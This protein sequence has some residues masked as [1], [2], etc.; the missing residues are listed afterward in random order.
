M[1]LLDAIRR[2][3]GLGFGFKDCKRDLTKAKKVI[4]NQLL[5]GVIHRTAGDVDA[6]RA[7]AQMTIPRP[8]A[9]FQR[10]LNQLPA[11]FAFVHLHLPV[12]LMPSSC[13]PFSRLAVS[14][15]CNCLQKLPVHPTQTKRN[16]RYAF[17]PK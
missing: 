10:W 6:A 11:C 15:I 16:A 13:Q 14:L 12:Y 7:E 17:R 2:R 1:A 9:R 3:L 8:A 5:I 4:E